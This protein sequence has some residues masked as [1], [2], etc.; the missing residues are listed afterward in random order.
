MPKSKRWKIVTIQP[1]S[2]I[3]RCLAEAEERVGED[4]DGVTV[5]QNTSGK[6]PFVMSNHIIE[7]IKVDQIKIVLRWINANRTEDRV[8]AVTDAGRMGTPALSIASMGGHLTLMT[9]LLQLG[10]N[11]D[12]RDCT[13]LTAIFYVLN[14]AII[15]VG[16]VDKMFRL[17]LAGGRTSFQAR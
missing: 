9:L 16:N 8:N 12:T 17:L 7:A 4:W 10:A 6:P 11:V 1:Q 3:S 13:G 5:L 15:L 2:V 14:S